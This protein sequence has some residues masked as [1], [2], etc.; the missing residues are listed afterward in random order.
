MGIPVVR[1]EGLP[2]LEDSAATPAVV[3]NEAFAERFFPGADP[4]GRRIRLASD[5]SPW[6]SITGV[7]RSVRQVSPEQPARE[8]VY[9]SYRRW[10]PH[11]TAFVVRTEG[12]P[13]D[14]QAAV[15]KAIHSV[16]PEQPVFGMMPIQELLDNANAARRFSLLLLTLFASVALL[17]AAIGIYGVMTYTTAQRQHEIGIRLALGALPADV[18][19][20]VVGRGMRVVALGVAI[21]LAGAWALSRVLRRQLFEITAGDPVTYVGAALLLGLVALAAN[22]VPAR[23]ASRTNPLASIRAE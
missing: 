22:Y 14:Y 21:G 13:Q 1:G 2:P 8:E 3:I 17:L 19:R 23:R 9:L 5:E 16:D 6:I 15:L 4:V 12:R 10:T 7:V 11:E 20:E 18:V